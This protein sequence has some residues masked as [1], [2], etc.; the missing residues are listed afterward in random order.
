[1]SGAGS[2]FTTHDVTECLSWELQAPLTIRPENFK[3]YPA[4][5]KCKVERDKMRKI[6]MQCHTKS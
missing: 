4:K 5:T 6:C 3:P 1:M 2:V